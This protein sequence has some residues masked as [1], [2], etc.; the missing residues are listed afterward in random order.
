MRPRENIEK[1]I[2]NFDID[3]NPKKDQ[4]IFDEL[5]EVQAKSKQSELGFSTI[6]IWRIIMKSKITK[7]ATA[8]V[9]I[10]AVLIGINRFGGSLNVTSVAF[11]D[12]RAAFLAQSWVH[13][14]YDN[15]TE[16]W[17]N[18]KTGDHG[19]KQ[20]YSW[21]ESFV[22]INR[23]DN[24]RWRYT[25]DRGKYISVDR[26]AT[27][28]NG[29]IPL[30]EPETAWDTIVGH[31]EEIAKMGGDRYYEVDI[32]DDT[33]D[34]KSSVRFDIY[35]IDALDRKLL[36]KQLW[37]DPTTKLPIKIQEKLTTQQQKE[38]SREYI[39][40]V[41]S[42]PE[43]GP[44]SIYDLG[45]PE[46]LPIA[47]NFDEVVNPYI[48]EILEVAKQ[49][50]DNFPKRCRAV[51]WQ[52]DYLGQDSEIEIIWRDGEKIHLNHYFN[53]DGEKNPQ[54]H[55]DVPA[56]VEEV[57]AWAK[58]QPPVSIYIDDE[59]KSYH[60]SHHPAYENLKTPKTRVTRSWRRGLPQEAHF[61]DKHWEYMYQ[62]PQCYKLIEDAPEELKQYIG[63]R[64]ENGMIRIRRDHYID[65]EH[66]YIRV[67][68][69]WWILRNGRWEK[70]REYI[71]I[72]M[73]QLPTGH[74]YETKRKLIIYPDPEKGYSKSEDNY[75]I[76]IK[77]LD[78]D[79]FPPD[80]FNGEKLLEDAEIE[81][82]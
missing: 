81:T 70:K 82:Y 4:Q 2:K 18:L 26:P 74:W 14:R 54:Y 22:Y 19:H 41:F 52:N 12:V 43:T 23:T 29:I 50:Y 66:D 64:R 24:L 69:I 62:K 79:E 51:I 59:K 46:G 77:L 80:T 63:I 10:V 13:L 32:Y 57:L 53:M 36:I 34:G 11:A 65:A 3:V 6:G 27:Y 48:E 58:T 28:E 72:E 76:N 15:N 33:L 71:N 7:F 55:L 30:H 67:R 17:Y 78:E 68:N 31:W 38:Q 60:R 45:V 25:P 8:A 9:I 16:S 5:R 44:L 37:A 56:S 1:I 39:T 42:F 49:H 75:L 61:I 21:G 47:K 73:A 35:Y 20:L 40:G